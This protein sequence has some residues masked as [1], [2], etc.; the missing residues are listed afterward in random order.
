MLA[1][2]DHPCGVEGVH[3]HLRRLRDA[4]TVASDP[5]LEVAPDGAD[6]GAGDRPTARPACSTPPTLAWPSYPSTLGDT[7]EALAAASDCPP[8][9]ST[10]P[11]PASRPQAA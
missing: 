2:L 6:G 10:P 4:G 3:R 5:Q 1:N 9:P 8:G 7:P 11:S